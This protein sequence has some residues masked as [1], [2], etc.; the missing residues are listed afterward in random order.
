ML[1][2]PCTLVI[3]PV[4]ILK[5]KL[6]KNTPSAATKILIFLVFV[7]A[8]LALLLFFKDSLSLEA[9][10]ESASAA[11]NFVENNRLEGILI[12]MAFYFAICSL[13]MPFVSVPTMIAG[14]L[15]GNIDGLLIVSFM[16]ALGGTCLFLITRY[17]C[18]DWIQKKFADKFTSLQK[19]TNTDSFM[20]AL[21]M[22]LVPGM[23][24]S[25]PAILLGLSRI[26]TLKFYAS[27]QLGLLIIL[28]VYVNAGRSLS[29][30]NS[31]QDIFSPQL[32][33]SML[34]LAVVPLTFGFISKKKKMLF[35]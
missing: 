33:L 1:P 21:S 32:V 22:R 26:S 14:F 24:F 2:L 3:Q 27:T 35:N 9:A 7:A 16:S 11:L 28:F 23:P 12:F 5:Q 30:I 10:K 13:P 15:F 20:V 4:K 8:T 34:L 25:F 19:A 31:V 17:L 18:S 29:E 6:L